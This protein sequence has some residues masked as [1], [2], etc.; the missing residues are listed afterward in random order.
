MQLDP[1]RTIDR[2]KP[3]EKAT[4]K[5]LEKFAKFKGVKEVVPGMPA[6]LMRQILELRGCTDI[7]TFLPHVRHRSIGQ[8]NGVNSERP[9]EAASKEQI[10]A[11]EALTRDWK[12]QQGIADPVVEQKPVLLDNP[13]KSFAQMKMHELR[14]FCKEQGIEVSRSDKKAD[15]IARLENGQNAP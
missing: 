13:G 11:I 8:M 7:H 1:S 14:T 6:P 10:S 5:E 12:A 3:L 2:R 9:S 4:R 15:L